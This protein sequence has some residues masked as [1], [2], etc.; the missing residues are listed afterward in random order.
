V[1][2]TVSTVSTGMRRMFDSGSKVIRGNKNRD[3]L[4]TVQQDSIPAVQQDSIPA[5]QQD[6]VPAVQQDDTSTMIQQDDKS[7]TIQQDVTSMMVNTP[8][9]ST[10][11][12]SNSGNNAGQEYGAIDVLQDA[13]FLS[14]LGSR[15]AQFEMDTMNGFSPVQGP[16]SQSGFSPVQGPPSQS[17]SPSDVNLSSPP[18]LS[19]SGNDSMTVTGTDLL[20]T[21]S[22]SANNNSAA[23]THIPSPSPR[24]STQSP[25]THQLQQTLRNNAH[26]QVNGFNYSSPARS[27]D[28]NDGAKAFSAF[29]ANSPTIVETVQEGSSD[30]GDGW[31]EQ[32]EG[33][34]GDS[35]NKVQ[36]E[37]IPTASGWFP[38]RSGAS[39]EAE[40]AYDSGLQTLAENATG[41]LAIDTNDDPGRADFIISVGALG[42]ASIA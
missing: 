10:P 42:N 39:N 25:V 16:P 3:S 17:A 24:R 20:D 28:G 2:D 5:V 34:A 29:N 31:P 38:P 21:Q 4:D 41:N 33:L 11:D 8:S 40:A 26:E 37:L 35:A 32:Q 6:S 9:I 1:A 23:G 22:A 18:R 30:D 12:G 7:T 36:V 19:P 13:S 15:T 27:S 14:D